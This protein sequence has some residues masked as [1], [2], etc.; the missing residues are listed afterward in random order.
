[1]RFFQNKDKEQPM[2]QTAKTFPVS[3]PPA[4][5]DYKAFILFYV[6]ILGLVVPVSTLYVFGMGGDRAS[7][8]YASFW[9]FDF[10]MYGMLLT[11]WLPLA[12]LKQHTNYDRLSLMVQVWIIVYSVIAITW[13]IPWLLMHDII[14]ANPDAIWTYSW[15]QYVDGGDIRYANPNLEILYAE[16]MACL[17]GVIAAIALY[18]WYKSGK[19]SAASIYTFMFCA[20]MHIMPTIYYYTHEI[21]SGLPNVDTSHPGNWLA[22]FIISNSCWLWM[23]FVLFYWCT[24]TL[25][26]LYT[27]QPA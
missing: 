26:R 20:V 27:N 21:L 3:N 11:P 5:K 2:A 7:T 10:A 19:S 6:A 22:K 1:L 16:T 24:Q 4:G 18:H 23:P 8:A 14:A 17:N 15:M 13:E 9:A 25:P 12:S